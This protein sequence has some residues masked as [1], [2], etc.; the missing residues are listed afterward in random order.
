MSTSSRYHP[1]LLFL[2]PSLLYQSL[3]SPNCRG[4][5]WRGFGFILCPVMYT[6]NLNLTV[7]P[8]LWCD[9]GIHVPYGLPGS[10]QWLPEAIPASVSTLQP[11]LCSCGSQ[12]RH[13]SDS[14][15][16]GFVSLITA[17][18][19][20][21]ATWLTSVPNTLS[22]PPGPFGPCFAFSSVFPISLHRSSSPM[23]RL[24]CHLGKAPSP[25]FKLPLIHLSAS[26]GISSTHC[27][28]RM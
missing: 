22:T 28:P 16:M 9:P 25:N 27:P 20:S 5:K 7:S 4:E 24:N 2:K 21:P 6:R 15:S 1:T 12:I 3:Y 11:E 13:S 10:Q 23:T 19:V 8:C 18:H 17:L 14:G 26:K